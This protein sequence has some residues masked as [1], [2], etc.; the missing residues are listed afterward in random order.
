MKRDGGRRRAA[1][2]LPPPEGLRSVRLQDQ[3]EFALM[4]WPLQSVPILAGEVTAAEAAVAELAA[5]GFTNEEIARARGRATR[6]IANQ[7]ASIY[8]KLGVGSR[9]ELAAYLARVS[10]RTTARRA[11]RRENGS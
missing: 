8:R 11:P 5:A 3:E 7:L 6:T 1:G 10:G 2:E 4:W 9:S